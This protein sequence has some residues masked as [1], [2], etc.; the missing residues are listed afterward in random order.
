MDALPFV[1]TFLSAA[2]SAVYLLKRPHGV[3]GVTPFLR[4]VGVTCVT[5]VVQRRE[6]CVQNITLK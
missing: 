1:A 4:S 6:R 2:I 5:V 3:T